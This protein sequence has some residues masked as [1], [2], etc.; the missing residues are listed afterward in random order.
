L[1]DED[2]NYAGDEQQLQPEALHNLLQTEAE[3]SAEH[4]QWQQMINLRLYSLT[5]SCAPIA[6]HLNTSQQVST[7]SCSTRKYVHILFY[8]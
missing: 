3:M 1:R 7:G 2:S 4:V 5:G 6:P 8:T